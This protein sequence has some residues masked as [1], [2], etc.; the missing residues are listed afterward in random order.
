VFSGGRSEELV[1]RGQSEHP[2]P[3]PVRRTAAPLKTISVS[4]TSAARAIFS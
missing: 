3:E 4:D 1:H 2:S